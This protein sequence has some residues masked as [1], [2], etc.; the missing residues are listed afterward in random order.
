MKYD[1][2]DTISEGTEYTVKIDGIVRWE[3]F[4]ESDE[5]VSAINA[6]WLMFSACE[7]NPYPKIEILK[8]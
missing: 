2:T 4:A 6:G 8:A 5:P 1:S 7:G 3:G